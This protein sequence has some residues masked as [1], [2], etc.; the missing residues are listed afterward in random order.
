[1]RNSVLIAVVLIF[2]SFINGYGQTP[3]STG[4]FAFDLISVD[5]D[6]DR[7]A[8]ESGVMSSIKGRL[9]MK[10]AIKGADHIVIYRSKPFQ[11]G[12]K[13]IIY[14]VARVLEMN[15]DSEQI[16]ETEYEDV[17][18]G[19]YF[20][21]D[22]YGDSTRQNLLARFV[23]ICSNDYVLDAD[24]DILL[25]QSKIEPVCENCNM[26]ITNESLIINNPSEELASVEIY[27]M[28]GI[29]VYSAKHTDALIIVDKALLPK[30]ICVLRLK[31]NNNYLTK[32]IRI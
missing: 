17:W 15:D 30:G 18:V 1:M 8:I 6:Y 12:V 10:F 31:I 5:Y 29:L 21:F 19:T 23:P 2:G 28:Q 4:D 11:K 13:P 20:R 3:Q 32:K 16:I 25:D 24:M 9:K 7:D 22:C 14:I 26:T 27:N